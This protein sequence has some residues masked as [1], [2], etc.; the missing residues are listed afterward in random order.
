[1]ILL[2]RARGFVC[3]VTSARELY[4]DVPVSCATHWNSAGADG[5]IAA[6]F[7]PLRSTSKGKLMKRTALAGA[8]LGTLAFPLFAQTQQVKPPIAVYWVSAETN[9]GM[10]VGMPAGFGGMLPAGMQGG[11]RLKLDLGSQQSASAPRAAHAIPATLA[12]GQSLPLLTPEAQPA[13]APRTGEEPQQYDRPKGRMLIYWG[14]GE[15]IRAG[16]PI[17]VDFAKMSGPE[18]SKA[19]RSHNVSRPQGPAFGRSRTYGDWP[20]R[21]NGTAVPQQASLIGDHTIAGNYS[22]EIGFAV[23]DRHDFMA[24]V[25][26]EPVRKTPAGAFQV[27]WQSIPTAIGYFATA[28]GQ[29]NQSDTVMWSSSDVQEMGHALM[30]YLPPSEVQ[31]LIRERVV[32]TPQTTDCAVPAGI[33]KGEGAMF[34]FIAYGDELNVVHPPRPGN[35]KQVWEQ[36]YAVKV[37]L[38]STGM[39]MLAEADTGSRARGPAPAQRDADAQQRGAPQQAERAPTGADAVQEGINVLRGLFGR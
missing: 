30:D 4:R 27:R 15:A 17:V 28:V 29:D 37:R 26:F 21:E 7:V 20:N 2:S 11:K 18:A 1:V 39:T 24:P 34:N 5:N 12:M 9:A 23:G 6:A 38:K 33:F 22:P 10:S 25:A 19:F 35:P 32:M 36:Q 8:V 3:S 16:Q 14:C 13:Q 31:R